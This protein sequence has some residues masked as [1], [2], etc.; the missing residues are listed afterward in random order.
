M[1]NAGRRAAGAGRMSGRIAKG[2][3][4]VSR[5]RSIKATLSVA[6][7]NRIF[8]MVPG[9]GGMR[10]DQEFKRIPPRDEERASPASLDTLM[11]VSMHMHST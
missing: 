10:G 7:M 6:D 2:D 4:D 3:V 8:V 9:A 5:I 1:G 11:N